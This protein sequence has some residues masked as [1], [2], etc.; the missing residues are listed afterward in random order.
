MPSPRPLSSPEWLVG[1]L[2]TV[3]G[4]PESQARFV[5][6]LSF[7]VTGLCILGGLV[8]LSLS[9]TPLKLAIP[10]SLVLV[11]LL[12]TVTMWC[13]YRYFPIPAQL[14]LGI[15]SAALGALIGFSL[16]RVRMAVGAF[17][18]GLIAFSAWGASIGISD[19]L[20]TAARAIGK[21]ILEKSESIPDGDEGFVTMLR[22]AFAAS[23][24]DMSNRDI[25]FANK[26]AILALGVILG[27]DK[28]ARVARREV[29]PSYQQK[30]EALRGRITLRGRNDLS[31]HFWV[32]AALVVISN[33]S[34]STTVGLA[35]EVMDTRPGGSGFSFV[36]LAADFA[37]VQFAVL[38][39]KQ[40]HEAEEMRKRVLM[41]VKSDDFCPSMEGL[42]EGLSAK[43][44]QEEYGGIGGKETRRLIN[45]IHDR[46][47]RCPAFKV[48]S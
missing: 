11:S 34:N 33:E 20:D 25:L 45:E 29:D 26:A 23:D 14:R 31:R 42:P 32:S 19:E 17:V 24:E 16:L 3:A 15:A 35:K 46:I 28:V 36:D 6:A 30:K 13:N 39:T 40:G 2:R 12:G 22:D 41:A 21:Q 48:G 38:A 9:S 8:S 18:F 43:Q 5:A 10:M 47:R 44:L 4:L 1:A 37:G 27:E 7:R